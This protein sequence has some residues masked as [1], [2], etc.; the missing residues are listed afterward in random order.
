MEAEDGEKLMS[1]DWIADI[2]ELYEALGGDAAYTAA[3]PSLPPPKIRKLRYNLVD[4]EMRE[5]LQAIT[6]D[7]IVGVADGIC[8]S[9]VVLIG[10]ALAYGIDL[11]PIWDEIHRTNMMKSTGPIRESDGKRLK[12]PNWEHPRVRELLWEQRNA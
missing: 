2:R 5:T 11:Q 3:K 9:F 1:S 7:N 4:E 10:T 12:P 6:S 8:D